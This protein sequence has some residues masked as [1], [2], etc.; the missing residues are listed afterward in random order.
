MLHSGLMR[1]LF[2]W[3]RLFLL[4]LPAIILATQAFAAESAALHIRTDQK[5]LYC[6]ARIAVDSNAFSPTM[7]DG[8]AMATEWHIKVRRVRSYWLNEDIADITVTRHAKPD[9][10]TRSWLL[11]ETSSGI[12]Q[13]VYS[14][15]DAIQFLSGLDDFPV[16]D[17]SL[18]QKNTP[19]RVSVSVE[20]HSEGISDAWWA[21][22]WQ[23]DA[24]SM[25]Q[26]FSLP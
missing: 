5:V 18:L 25:Q 13:R 4:L 3:S 10:L 21:G 20:I 8:I 1:N 26:D 11:T 23:P 6:A 17:R 2:P 19:Y 16:L 9:L 7:K 12:S 14:L 24:A 15:K 22:L